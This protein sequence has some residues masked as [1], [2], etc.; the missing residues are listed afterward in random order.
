MTENGLYCT[1]SD[2]TYAIT[3][4]P[5]T[6]CITTSGMSVTWITST[7]ADGGT[8]TITLTATVAR[9][10][11]YSVVNTQSFTLVIINC[12]SSTDTVTITPYTPGP[13]PVTILSNVGAS[14]SYT[15]HPMSLTSQYC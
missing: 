14:G 15:F 12:A 2:I 10:N 11:G 4:S 7:S 8:Y 6:S 3:V 9:D 13:S 1:S 5:A